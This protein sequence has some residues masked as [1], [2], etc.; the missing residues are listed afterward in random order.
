LIKQY[1]YDREILDAKSKKRYKEVITE[2]KIEPKK[3]Y[4]HFQSTS[5]LSKIAIS[6]KL[7]QYDIENIEFITKNYEI[8]NEILKKYST[9]NIE[10]Y[11]YNS[12]NLWFNNE[13]Y[14]ELELNTKD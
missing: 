4:K 11:G 6:L 9:L 1:N 5:K 8:L 14:L 3:F 12:K 7:N 13:I 10:F 2:Q